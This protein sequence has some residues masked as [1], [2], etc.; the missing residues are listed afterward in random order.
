VSL[1]ACVYVRVHMT[2]VC[3]CDRDA[4]DKMTAFV[5]PSWTAL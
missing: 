5:I 2:Y 1:C 3:V 4:G